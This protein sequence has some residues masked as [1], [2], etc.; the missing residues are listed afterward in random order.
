MNL[1][2]STKATPT[3]LC[4]LDI[5]DNPVVL[6]IREKC[7]SVDMLSET[8]KQDEI[9]HLRA[10]QELDVTVDQGFDSLLGSPS[11]G[12]ASTRPSKGIPTPTSRDSL[13]K[14][15]PGSGPVP[16]RTRPVAQAPKA[17]VIS[18]YSTLAYKPADVKQAVMFLPLYP[19]LLHV[20]LIR[21][22]TEKMQEVRKLLR[23]VGEYMEEDLL[24]IMQTGGVFRR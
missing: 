4:E 23:S 17:L 21:L 12:P 5:Y 24:R 19:S 10:E 3:E 15:R 22:Q 1:F 9:N 7:Y 14:G 20:S 6:R 18:K 11:K 16:A 8:A 13:G 2:D